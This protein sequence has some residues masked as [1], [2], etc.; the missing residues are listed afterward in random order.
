MP[1]FWLTTVHCLT[2]L[3][4]QVRL[5]IYRFI[6]FVRAKAKHTLTRHDLKG[7]ALDIATVCSLCCIFRKAYRFSTPNL[8]TQLTVEVFNAEESIKW[9]QAHRLSCTGSHVDPL[10]R[11]RLTGELSGLC[12]CQDAVWHTLVYKAFDQIAMGPSGE[13]NINM[14]ASQAPGSTT[15]WHTSPLKFQPWWDGALSEMCP[16]KS[17]TVG[18]MLLEVS[19][20][21]RLKNHWK[22]TY[23]ERNGRI[24]T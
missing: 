17:Y 16:Y 21:R 12:T 9:L 4:L 10:V 5:L 7:S 15:G 8:S 1:A 18:S 11:D 6:I 23:P 14:Q 24:S 20:L 2:I 19:N 3:A 22:R 13:E